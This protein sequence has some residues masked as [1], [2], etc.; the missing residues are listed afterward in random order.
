MAR[1]KQS[2]ALYV[3]LN[4]RLVGLLRKASSGAVSF[5]YD[6]SWL[7]WEN[8][9]PISFSLPLQ[10]QAFVGGVVAAVFD[11]LLPDNTG[12]RQQIAARV[13]AS[14][15]GV[16]D[17]LANI[18]RD[19]VGALQFLREGESPADV[20]HVKGRPLTEAEIARK[21]RQLATTPLGMS[22][23]DQ[24]FRISLAGAQEKTALLYYEG[25][26]MEP[27]GSTPTTHIL[28]PQIG[29]KGDY[30]LNQSVENEH[31][32]MTF[33]REL[34]LPVP[35]TA[36]VDFEGTR[37][38]SVE[39]FDRIW[40]HD[41]R[42]LRR[43][44][45]DFCQA[46]GVPS[47]QKY[48]NAG[49]PG[50]K[51]CM[52]FLKGSDSPEQDRRTFMKAQIVYWLL[53]ATDGHAKNFSV[54]IT[55]GGRFYMTPLYDIMSVQP[56]RDRGE[57]QK[58]KMK[59]A[60]AVLGRTKHYQIDTIQKRHFEMTAD[61]CGFSPSELESIFEELRQSTPLALEKTMVAMPWGFPEP[62]TRPIRRGVLS[63]LALLTE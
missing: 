43:P 53:G 3:Y 55:S 18:G 59:M 22:E 39:R 17:L 42:L 9:F 26:W 23:D 46:L 7:T 16:F 13:G 10:E 2:E 50:I 1:P 44:Q 41:G 63:R 35:Q 20:G 32:C 51:E 5:T 33:C 58:N 60:M 19:C 31:F 62:M 30:D 12:V 25:K 21:I 15:A 45:E 40:T 37:V 52:N 36:I 4:G 61:A 11:N 28:K 38:I 57:I 8:T 34:G 27:H 49:G 6:A 54:F 29:R 47:S 48:E 24:E 14:S 56:L